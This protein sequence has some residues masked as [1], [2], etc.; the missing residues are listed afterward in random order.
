MDD[1]E[2]VLKSLKQDVQKSVT[3]SGLS[4]VPREFVSVID[5][6]GEPIEGPCNILTLDDERSH[7]FSVALSNWLVK[8]SG[9]MTG[10]PLADVAAMIRSE[11]AFEG[12]CLVFETL[13]S[14]AEWYSKPENR[15]LDAFIS[16]FIADG[17]PIYGISVFHDQV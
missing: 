8:V 12:R 2:R 10:K 9:N 14:L 13:E 4:M 3:L 1:F 5:R 11:S 17:F 16:Y 6:Y 15:S 7:K